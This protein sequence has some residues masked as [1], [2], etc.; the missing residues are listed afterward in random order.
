MK[1]AQ[2]IAKV[3]IKDWPKGIKDTFSAKFL[4]PS[5]DEKYQTFLLKQEIEIPPEPPMYYRNYDKLFNT[6]RYQAYLTWPKYIDQSARY[7]RMEN[8]I[9]RERIR[10]YAQEKA[11]FEQLAKKELSLACVKYRINDEFLKPFNSNEKELKFLMHLWFK[12][13]I[14]TKLL[15]H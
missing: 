10:S 14:K 8:I 9:K 5:S 2:Q 12:E 15:K 7:E 13:K 3:R 11:L 4:K 6:K 1:L